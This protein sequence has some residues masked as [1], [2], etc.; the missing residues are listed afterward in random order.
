MNSLHVVISFIIVLSHVHFLSAAASSSSDKYL[1]SNI[2][3]T[4]SNVK[5]Q[6][7]HKDAAR[8]DDNGNK[9]TPSSSISWETFRLRAE[10]ADLD[11]GDEFR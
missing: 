8:D 10:L 2:T 9:P 5:P 7:L 6:E 3:T 1:H 11:G 4:T